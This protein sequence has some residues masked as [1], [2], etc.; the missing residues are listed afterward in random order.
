MRIGTTE[1]LL[2]LFIAFLIFGPSRLP[3]IGEVFGKTIRS[4][5][6]SL[7]ITEP[8]AAKSEDAA[9]EQ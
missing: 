8:A 5:K 6:K 3:K 4:F 9:D 1:L 7:D 2:I